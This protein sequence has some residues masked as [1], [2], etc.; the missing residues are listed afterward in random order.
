MNTD[1]KVGTGTDSMIIVCQTVQIEQF[2]DAHGKTGIAVQVIG[3]SLAD[4]INDMLD[5]Y[6]Y[7]KLIEI[8]EETNK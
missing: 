8:I 3:Y 2:M 7:E 5:N 4:A 1:R 6:G